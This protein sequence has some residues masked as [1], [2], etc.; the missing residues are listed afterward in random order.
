MNL[1]LLE[2]RKEA[3]EGYVFKNK[4]TGVILGQVIYLGC[5]DKFENYE[6]VLKPVEEENELI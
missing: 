5:K 1:E 6:E 2:N 4:K 3:Q